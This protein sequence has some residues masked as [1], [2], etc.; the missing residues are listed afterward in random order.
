MLLFKTEYLCRNQGTLQGTLIHL[1][2]NYKEKRLLYV[3]WKH[4]RH[5]NKRSNKN[6]VI[7]YIYRLGL[8]YIFLCVFLTQTDAEVLND[9]TLNE[10]I[11]LGLPVVIVETEGSIEPTYEEV[12]APEGCLGGS[13]RNATKEQGRVVVKDTTGIIYDSGNYVKDNSGM[14][15]KVRGNWSARR[16]KKPYRIK[17]QK[18][19]DLLGRGEKRFNDKKW[20]LLPFFDLN[21]MI[22]LKVNELMEMQWTPQYRFVN[23][24]FNGDFRG[25]YLLMEAVGRNADCRIHVDK[26]TGFIVELDP[27]WWNEPVYLPS[28]VELPL[29]YTFKHPDDD[30]VTEEQMSYIGQVLLEAESAMEDSTGL[31]E[32]KIDVESFARWMLAHDIL[33][34]TDGAGSNIFLTKY[35]D[36]EGSL[37]KMGCLWDFEVIM[38]SE[39]WDDIH[40]RYYFQRL[41]NNSDSTFTNRYKELW[42]ENKD[43]VF[44]E[45]LAFLNDYMNSDLK[46]AIDASIRLNNNRWARYTY[47][48]PLSSKFISKARNYFTNRKE[49]LDNA[50]RNLCSSKILSYPV[51]PD[52]PGPYYTLQGIRVSHP[53]KGGIYIQNG[54]KRIIK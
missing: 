18:K 23:L 28:S 39:E 8:L 36:T 44:D 24:V 2:I 41:F 3:F 33:G 12:D 22:G 29:N 10:L 19:A 32:Q 14:T 43:R 42:E 46:K 26:E 15:V 11:K 48:L 13:I 16:P 38:K 40:G 49:W 50:I 5:T 53:I 45:L 51:S 34:N 4:S 31:Y 17:L 9:S 7:K 1:L 54:R 27:Y 37:L 30:E 35:D 6:M 21:E 20:L 47:K 25:L 52:L